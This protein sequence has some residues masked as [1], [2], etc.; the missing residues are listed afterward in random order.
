[1]ER[2]KGKDKNTTKS[3]LIKLQNLSQG[4]NTK[5]YLPALE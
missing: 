3:E 2:K 5:I 1:M 4:N